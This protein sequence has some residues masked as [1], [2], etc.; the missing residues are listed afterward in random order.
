VNE[1]GECD[2]PAGYSLS[3]SG[4]NPCPSN[5]HSNTTNSRQCFF[6]SAGYIAQAGAIECSK[7]PNG[8]FRAQGQAEC[9]SCSVGWYAP[10]ATNPHS[11]VACATGCQQGEHAMP[12]PSN[13][14]RSDLFQCVACDPLPQNAYWTSTGCNYHCDNGYYHTLDRTCKACNASLCEPGKTK[15]A[16]TSDRDSDCDTDC[17]NSTKPI[18]YS[19]W[20]N[21]CEWGC[22]PGYCMSMRDYLVFQMWECIRCGV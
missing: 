14:G 9:A 2:C 5:S 16:C 11:C 13:E 12:C 7:C 10:D 18:F 4:C 8:Q 1:N 21:G 20:K 3:T 19:T 22:I 6:C 15:S 17:I